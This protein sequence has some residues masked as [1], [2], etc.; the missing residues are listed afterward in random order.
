MY[1][2]WHGGGSIPLG[3]IFGGALGGMGGTMAGSAIASDG[4]AKKEPKTNWGGLIFWVVVALPWL[5]IFIGGFVAE[6]IGQSGKRK[7]TAPNKKLEATN[8]SARTGCRSRLSSAIR[9]RKKHG[10]TSTRTAK[11]LVAAHR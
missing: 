9:R 11:H 3:A 8:D 10:K 7:D 2:A 5:A 4:Q 6:L 1:D